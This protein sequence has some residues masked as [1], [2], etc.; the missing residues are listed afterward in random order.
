MRGSY[1]KVVRENGNKELMYFHKHCWRKYN[2]YIGKMVT[3]PVWRRL[4]NMIKI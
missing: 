4:R 2:S 1:L 3:E